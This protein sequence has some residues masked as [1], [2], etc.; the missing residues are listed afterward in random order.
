MMLVLRK[1]QQQAMQQY[2]LEQYGVRTLAHF[3]RFFPRHCEIIGDDPMKNMIRLGVDRA[4]R[5]A[6]VGETSS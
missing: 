3:Q 2:M 6:L 1:E 4:K 5:H